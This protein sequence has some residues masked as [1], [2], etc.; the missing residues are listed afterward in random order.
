MSFL[1]DILTVSG[2]DDAEI[3]A[4]Q[5]MLDRSAD[6]VHGGRPHA[7]S[8]GAF[9]GSAAGQDLGLQTTTAHRHVVE[10][11]DELVVGLRGYRANI[12]KWARD[13][14][15]TDSAA[16]ATMVSIQQGIQQSQDCAASSDFHAN[17]VCT[18]PTDGGE[19]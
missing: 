18:V 13:M 6:A 14:A 8:A 15:S 11:L 9:G 10:A 5:A 4:I 3:Q 1:E 7:F 17:P 12:Q 16:Q 2:L 19:G